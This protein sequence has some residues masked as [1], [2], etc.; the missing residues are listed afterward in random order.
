MNR[1]GHLFYYPPC[2]VFDLYTGIYGVGFFLFV[3]NSASVPWITC[4]ENF[5]FLANISETM[6]PTNMYYISLERSLYSTS[7][8]VSC[9][10]IHAE[11][12]RYYIIL[13]SSF[14]IYFFC[15]C[16]SGSFP[17]IQTVRI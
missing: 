14:V 15:I 12:K 7:A 17:T 6:L 13:L 8:G 9:I 16:H 1:V 4:V 11:I 5:R 3:Y 2:V 10:K